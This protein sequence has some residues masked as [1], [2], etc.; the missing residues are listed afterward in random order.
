MSKITRIRGPTKKRM[1][2]ERRV[3]GK[4]G[5]TIRKIAL[6]KMFQ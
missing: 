3:I 6:K 4:R 5:L 1:G 2:V